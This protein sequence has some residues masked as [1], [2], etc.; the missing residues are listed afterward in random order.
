MPAT[1][2]HEGRNETLKID[3]LSDEAVKTS[4][5]E[6]E[7]LNRDSVQS[8]LRH[9]FGLGTERPGV[10]PQERGISRMM[11]D[12]YRGCAGAPL[13]DDDD[14]RLARHAARAE[15]PPWAIDRRLPGA[16]RSP[17]KSFPARTMSA[18]LQFEGAAVRRVLPAEMQAVHRMVR[19]TRR[20]AAK[21]PLPALTRAGMAHLYFVCIHPFE[22]GNGRIGRALAEKSLAQNLGQPSLITLAYTIERKRNGLLRRAGAQQQRK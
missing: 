20:R 8:S 18:L 5:I 3:F 7:I 11:V 9:Q 13:T 6:G 21:S 12:L 16:R 14:V 2:N 1:A 22:D 4:Q 19:P 17:C 10:K 15:I